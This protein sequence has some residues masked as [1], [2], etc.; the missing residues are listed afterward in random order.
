MKEQ[1]TDRLAK[2][3][4]DELERE[5]L[6]NPKIKDLYIKEMVKNGDLP[7]DYLAEQGEEN[8]HNHTFRQI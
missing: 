4:F 2:N 1:Y 5:V 8:G 6:S 3:M 7:E